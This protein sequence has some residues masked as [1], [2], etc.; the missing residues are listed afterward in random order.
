LGFRGRRSFESVD[1]ELFFWHD[2][3]PN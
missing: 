2:E 3:A 1:V